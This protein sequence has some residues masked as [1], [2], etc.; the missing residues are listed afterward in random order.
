MD[1]ELDKACEELTGKLL[2]QFGGPGLLA[3]HLECRYRDIERLVHA[4]RPNKWLV[5]YIKV[6]SNSLSIFH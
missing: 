1:K 4:K 3:K 5:K 2:S 6:L